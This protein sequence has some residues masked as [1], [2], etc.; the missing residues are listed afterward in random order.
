MSALGAYQRAQLERTRSACDLPYLPILGCVML[1]RKQ[2]A[3]FSVVEMVTAVGL[4]T[5]CSLVALPNAS[6]ILDQYRLIAA[7]SQLSFEISRAHMQAV[8]QNLFVRI[9]MLDA[10]GYVREYSNDNVTFTQDGPCTQFPAG[11]VVRTGSSGAPSFNR[12]GLATAA[13]TIMLSNGSGYKTVHT[14]ILGRVTIPTTGSNH[15]T[16]CQ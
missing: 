3:G 16:E 13:T 10:G 8:G 15:E 7:A 9:R 6:K 4:T 1:H 12:G 5:I 14:N 2:Q 11:L